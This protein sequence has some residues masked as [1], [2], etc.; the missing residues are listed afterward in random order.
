MR[1]RFRKAAALTVGIT[2]AITLGFGSTAG[3]TSPPPPFTPDG[4]REVLIGVGS[5]TTFAVMGCPSGTTGT[6]CGAT[7]AGLSGVLKG[8]QKNKPLGVNPDPTLTTNDFVCNVAPIAA[9]PFPTSTT[10]AADG[11]HGAVTYNTS[12]IAPNGSTA[13]ITALKNDSGNGN[14][15]YARSS[16]GPASPGDPTNL[17]FWAYALDAVTWIHFVNTPCPGTDTGPVGCAPKNLTQQNLIDI[18][19]CPTPGSNPVVS[20][21]SAVAGDAGAIARY[22][23]QTGSG[24]RSFFESRLLGGQ[25]S[26]DADCTTPTTL[27]QENDATAVAAGDRATAILP[28]SVANWNAQKNLAQGPD[29]RSGTKLG[30]VNGVLPDATTITEGA[31]L[32][33]SCASVPA[34]TFCGTRF[35]Y[36]VTDTALQTTNPAA[37]QATINFLG[38]DVATGNP[39]SVC[40]NNAA[41]TITTFGFTPLALGA[42][43]SSP[44]YNPPGNSYCRLR[45][46]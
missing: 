11:F 13:G 8:Y 19:S 4:A 1:F 7:G 18:Y 33:A 15:D 36:N 23:P 25:S 5:D 28:Y 41:A 44:T 3:A 17:Q 38:V 14:I 37:Y 24:T 46:T 27:V 39:G 20:N 43:D 31:A 45:S 6:I 35:V 16:R 40:S 34:G 10:C 42:T 9:A 29:L 26:N 2:S 22:T 30:K 12:N 32:A 21:W